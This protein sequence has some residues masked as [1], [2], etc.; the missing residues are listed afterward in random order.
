MKCEIFALHPLPLAGEGR[1]RGR[2]PARNRVYAV[3]HR[4]PSKPQSGAIIALCPLLS[5][6]AFAQE[7]FRRDD[8]N[9]VAGGATGGTWKSDGVERHEA[10][11]IGETT[12]V[13]LIV[14]PRGAAK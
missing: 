12:A 9:P 4:R 7:T 11:N 3:S 14:E 8:P 13:Y 2:R 5:T 10:V 1:V 6:P